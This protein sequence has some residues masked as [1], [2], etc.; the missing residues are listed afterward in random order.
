[1]NGLNSKMKLEEGICEIEVRAIEMNN[2]N[3]P[4]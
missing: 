1:M 3:Y 4:I 2:R